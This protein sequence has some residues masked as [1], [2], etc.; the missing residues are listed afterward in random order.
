MEKYRLQTYSV[1]DGTTDTETRLLVTHRFTFL[2]KAFP[3]LNSHTKTRTKRNFETRHVFGSVEQYR[4]HQVQ[5]SVSP[6]KRASCTRYSV[7]LLLCNT[8]VQFLNNAHGSLQLF[9]LPLLFRRFY[10][11]HLFRS[12]GAQRMCIQQL[13][14]GNRTI[15]DTA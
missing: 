7:Y 6:R 9:H 13:T 4:V 12:V 14:H 8:T 1:L 15:R 2:L 5:D 3:M 10:R 11:L